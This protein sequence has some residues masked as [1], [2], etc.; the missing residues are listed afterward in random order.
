MREEAVREERLDVSLLLKVDYKVV[1]GE[2]DG[3]GEA[4]HAFFDFAVDKTIDSDV[5]ECVM[6]NDSSWDVFEFHSHVLRARH[7]RVH[8]KKLFA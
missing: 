6:F 2:D 1:V 3:L 7:W 8:I 5:F 4:V